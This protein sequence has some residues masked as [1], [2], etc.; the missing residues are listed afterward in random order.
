[1]DNIEP[2]L[3]NTPASALPVW[4]VEELSDLFI[5]A[6]AVDEHSQ[7]MFLSVFGRDGAIQQLLSAFHLPVTEGGI[8]KLTIV[9]GNR[10]CDPGRRGKVLVGDPKRFGKTTGKLPRGLFGVVTQVFIYDQV[11][12][13][14]DRGS[15]AAWVV[16]HDA[17][18]AQHRERVW[19][20]LQQI[21]PLPVLA[22]WREPLLAS[23]GGSIAPVTHLGRVRAS[24]I[25]I[26]LDE[27]MERVSQLVRQGVL[28]R[29]PD[30][31]ASPRS[32]ASAA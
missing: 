13:K 8:D 4:R 2:L 32:S 28:T 1:M 19:R 18:D 20:T 14:V 6:I 17:S 23:I 11:I 5:D 21:L 9:P 29:E 27:V 10:N 15:G 24:R 3:R 25:C 7:I 31:A 12:A 22:H 16:S 26:D 30:S